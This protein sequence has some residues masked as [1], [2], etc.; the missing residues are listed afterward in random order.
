MLNGVLPKDIE[1]WAGVLFQV[2]SVQAKVL[3]I[4]SIPIF[5]VTPG[6]GECRFKGNQ[7]CAIKIKGSAFLLHQVCCMVAVLLMIGQGLESPGAGTIPKQH[8][9]YV[10]YNFEKIPQVSSFHLGDFESQTSL[11][12]I[13]ALLDTRRTPRKPQYLMA[14]EI[15]LVLLPVSLKVSSLHVLQ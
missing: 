11:Q 7:L 3:N 1:L 9:A 5:H 10:V 15:P 4:N 8:S 12:L 2:T 14:P 6:Y 13:D